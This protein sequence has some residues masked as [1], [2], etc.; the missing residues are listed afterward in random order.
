MR[1]SFIVSIKA[2]GDFVIA[3]NTL[4]AVR[5]LPPGCSDL[6]VLAGEHLKQL[7]G[8][9]QLE[10]QVRFIPS[11]GNFP[12]AFDVR[13]GGILRAAVSLLRLRRLF[14]R[15]PSDCE[16]IFDQAGWRERLLGSGYRHL[17]FLSAPN[18]YQAATATLRA[19]GYLL[20]EGPAA[21]AAATSREARRT[22]AIF[23]S[24]RVAHKTIPVDVIGRVVDQLGNAGLHPEVIALAGE[25]LDLPDGAPVRQIERNF[26]AVTDA[27]SGSALVVSADSVPA[28][29]AEYFGV[30]TY[31]LSPAPNE[32]WLPRSSFLTRGWSLFCDDRALPSW[33]AATLSY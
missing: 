17:S 2:F 16:L 10:S 18:I 9:L 14:A 23:A 6:K 21:S 28:H 1:T 25:R 29:L 4:R 30:P 31:V 27:I 22:A 11:G 13:G 8:A 24:S 7:A 32:Y 15:L 3:A 33:L 26:S 12:G 5:K 19:A 20:Q